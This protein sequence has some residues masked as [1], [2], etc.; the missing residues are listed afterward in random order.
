M[1]DSLE[2]IDEGAFIRCEVAHFR[3]PPLTSDVVDISILGGNKCLVSLEL[4]ENINRIEE[5]GCT[6]LGA[7][8]NIAVPSNCELYVDLLETCTNLGT[9][10][11]DDDNDTITDALQHRFDELPIHKICYYQSYHDTET[12]MQ[13]LKREIN[14][15]TFKLPGQLNT[16][17]K[18]KDCLGMTPL[19]IL[20]CSTKPT[21]EMYRLLICKYPETLVTKDKWGDI[22]LLYA[23]WCGAP[24]E[25]IDLLVEGYKTLHPD[26]IF[27]W[28]GM[29]QTLAKRNVPLDIVKRLV[30]TQQN[31]FPDQK[32]DMQ[33]MVMELATYDANRASL[34]EPYTYIETFRYLFQVSIRK[35]LDSLGIKKWREDLG[36]IISTFPKGANKRE[37]GTKALYDR[38]DTYESI[39]EGIPVLELALWKAK[40]DGGRNKRSR[41]EG[42]DSYK[43]QC[44]I[45]CGADIII[46]NV[47]PYLLPE[48]GKIHVALG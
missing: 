11:P 27:D 3:I 7:L 24:L 44:R 32:Y 13:S 17:G 37:E 6:I 39:K 45:N 30:T 12:T 2:I 29:I 15:W 19:H 35:R 9:V 20:A 48:K 47:L 40:L 41:V 38:L 43:E 42:N 14:P 4:S 22:P 23:I 36:D 10:F 16:T 25:V 21:I 31:S 18:E 5:S 46:R 33:S 28:S 1:H 26:S 34:Y 8:R